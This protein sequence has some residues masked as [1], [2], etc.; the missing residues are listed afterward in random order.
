MLIASDIARLKICDGIA[1]HLAIR[2]EHSD[3]GTRFS[4]VGKMRTEMV[5]AELG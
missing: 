5:T 2:Y 1:D 4:V 3:A